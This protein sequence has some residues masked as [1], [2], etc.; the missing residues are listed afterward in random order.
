MSAFLSVQGLLF[1]NPDIIQNNLVPF[2]P[3][4]MIDNTFT[5]EDFENILVQRC[6]EMEVLYPDPDSFAS[7]LHSWGAMY[8]KAWQ[9]MYDAQEKINTVEMGEVYTEDY[10]N[11]RSEENTTKGNN[12]S[13]TGGSDSTENKVA[14]FNSDG[15]VNQSESITSYGGTATYKVDESENKSG[16][17]SGG[18][19]YNKIDGKNAVEIEQTR[20]DVAVR[21][22]VAAFIVDQF[23]E[24]FCLM[25]Y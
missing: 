17:S 13:T 10:H 6:W 7:L 11:N 25:V 18:R 14:G 21:Q 24:M 3:M 9:K 22:E 23:A 5:G 19:T 1:N 8:Q 2:L 12:S 4:G 15:Y 16:N 20:Y